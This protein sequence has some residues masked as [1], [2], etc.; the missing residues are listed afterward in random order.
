MKFAEKYFNCSESEIE[1][2]ALEETKSDDDAG[3]DDDL[4]HWMQDFC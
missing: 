2:I 4:I 1:G 3:C